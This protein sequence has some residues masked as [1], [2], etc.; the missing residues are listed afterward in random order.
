MQK[1][2][3]IVLTID[4]KQIE[5]NHSYDVDS[6]KPFVSQENGLNDLKEVI[7]EDIIKNAKNFGSIPYNNFESQVDWHVL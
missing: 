3:N 2:E 6:G 1:H 7:L 5:I 4:N